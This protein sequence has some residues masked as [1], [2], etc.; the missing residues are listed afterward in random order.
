MMK[1]FLLE[2]TIMKKLAAHPH[3]NVVEIFGMCTAPPNL[4]IVTKF[5]S[6]GCLSS[7][8]ELIKDL[9]TVLQVARGIA[10]GMQMLHHQ[11]IV[12]RDHAARNCLLDY[13]ETKNL[14]VKITDF[15]MSRYSIAPVNQT[16]TNQF[17]LKWSAPES[18]RS[19]QY[20]KESDV[21]SYGVTLVEV[22]N[23]GDPYPG[24]PDQ[25]A[26]IAVRDGKL[27]PK[28]PES[29]ATCPKELRTLLKECWSFN[30]SSRP[31]F[32]QI[33]K[34]LGEIQKSLAS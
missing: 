7:R 6:L 9:Q 1:E 3:K 18:L 20:G 17:A 22:F 32:F 15:G 2:V 23:K 31:T 4:C 33:C 25:E 24:L 12:H 8:F 29:N 30:A 28:L 11:A 10:E 19:F 27:H 34:K 13:D 16:T 21:W 26:A 14:V 5:Y